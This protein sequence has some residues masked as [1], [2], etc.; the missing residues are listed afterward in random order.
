[1]AKRRFQLTEEEVMSFQQAEARTRDARELKR[2]Q[3]VRLYGIGETV[4]SIQKLVGC[5][6][7]SPRQWACAYRQ[8]GLAALHTNWASGNANK[9]TAAQ[10]QDL[11]GKL[12][13]Y[14]PD[15]VISPDVRVEQGTF[16]TVGDLQIVVERWYGVTYSSETSYRRLLHACDLSY[17]K[18][19]KVYRS[20][21][22]AVQLADFEADL[23]KN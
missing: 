20:Q 19:E 22:G 23:E 14:S 5:G 13:Q 1:M 7:A 3:A 10:R 21:P 6:P 17:Q 8:A 16:W 11:F 4:A 15:Q 18:V 2:L 12:N 9:L